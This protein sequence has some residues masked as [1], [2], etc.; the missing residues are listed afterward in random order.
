MYSGVDE[1]VV[2][3]ARKW[4][5]ERKSSTGF[6][7]NAAS[8]DSF[9]RAPQQVTDAFIVWTLVR[10]GVGADQLA[11]QIGQLKKLALST[12]VWESDPYFLAIVSDVL[13]MLKDE[14]AA[15]LAERLTSFVQADGSVSEPHSTITLSMGSSKLVEATS[16]A[17]L[18]WMNQ[19]QKFFPHIF[20]ALKFLASSCN[21][22]RFGSTQATVLALK[23]IVE[24][25]LLFPQLESSGQVSLSVNGNTVTAL[26]SES[27]QSEISIP[28]FSAFLKPGDN[29]I[30]ITLDSKLN[31]SLPSFVSV[32]F[33]TNLPPSSD[34]SPLELRTEFLSKREIVEGEL[35]QVGVYVENKREENLGMSVVM[36]GIPGG[37]QVREEK[38]AEMV[39]SGK[40]A[41]YESTQT[42]V[43]LYFYSFK[44]KEV[45]EIVLEAT[46]HCPGSF[47]AL[48][49]CAYAYYG[50]DHKTWT[51]SPLKARIS[52][53]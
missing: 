42:H 43:V 3:R 10:A 24:F 46:A 17:M 53:L 40:V 1:Q 6:L 50:D 45:K 25:D 52:P 32:D 31:V 8:L 29:S 39:R 37:L 27:D 4:L 2:E 35:V 41:F 47:E 19:P 34:L 26:F 5:I 14:Q 12:K 21:A 9:G 49:S 44:S 33:K 15:V 36:V 38:L 23:A 28:D 30:E 22:G 11:S 20:S 7:R 48:P 13:F 18:A 51:Q 16:L